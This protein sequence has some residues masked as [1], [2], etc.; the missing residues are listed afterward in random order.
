MVVAMVQIGIVRMNVRHRLMMMNMR[1]RL[2]SIPRKIMLMTM[3][4][5]MRM[6]MRVIERFVPM[7]MGMTLHDMQSNAGRHQTS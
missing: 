5:F 3:V 1:V 2:G 4:C 7:G 6:R